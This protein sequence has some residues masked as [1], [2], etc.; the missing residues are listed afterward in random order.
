MTFLIC[1]DSIE[2]ALMKVISAI[3][4]IA[5][6]PLLLSLNKGKSQIILKKR[7]DRKMWSR[8]KLH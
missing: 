8:S 6:A 3:L 1:T 7:K 2:F 4:R 5:L